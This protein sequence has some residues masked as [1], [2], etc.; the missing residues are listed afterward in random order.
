MR[1]TTTLAA[2]TMIAALGLSPTRAAEI[3]TFDLPAF[4]AVDISSGVDAEIIVGGDQLV[5]AEAEDRDILDKLELSVRNGRLTVEIDRN[6]L[7]FI[8]DG[9]LSEW[10]SGGPKI[11]VYLS[12]PV[13]TWLEA[14]S[15][16]DVR[17]RG[18][19]GD[20]LSI[21]AAS[22]AVID[23]R[24]LSA[25]FIA[26]DGSRGAWAGVS[27]SCERLQ[28]DVSSGATLS[29]RKLICRHA[30]V[31]A[32]SGARVSVH[33]T[34]SVDAEASSGGRVD[35]FG[36]PRVIEVDTSSGGDVDFRG[37]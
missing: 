25:G 23:A 31:E 16:S 26:V 14:S 12:A 6:F 11:T 35:V 4:D 7:D 24:E 22:G 13:L 3:R 33:A 1:G 15:G 5:R 32:S 30:Q 36:A 27:G 34:E 21:D 37:S 29:L 18:M 9:G 17:V 19:T 20:N 2:A 10:F 8:F 28:G